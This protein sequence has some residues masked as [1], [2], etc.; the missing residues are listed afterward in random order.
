MLLACVSRARKA[1]HVLAPIT[2]SKRACP[3]PGRTVID[4]H[5]PS[6]SDNPF[7]SLLFHRLHT[8]MEIDTYEEE[9]VQS[10]SQSKIPKRSFAP[11]DDAHP[12]DL[13]TYISGYSG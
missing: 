7:V 2:R 9:A 1:S 12:F 11:V 10:F 8:T 13:E 6:S 3:W 5:S 4:C